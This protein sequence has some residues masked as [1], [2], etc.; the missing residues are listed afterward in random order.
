MSNTKTIAKNTG[1]YGVD[2]VTNV[3]VSA[4][5]SIAIARTLGPTKTGYIVFV[6]SVA[7]VVGSFGG[8]GIPAATRKSPAQFI[9]RGDK[10]TARYIFSRTFWMQFVLASLRPLRASSF[11]CFTM[12]TRSTVLPQRSSR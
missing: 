9:G 12:P 4:I 6:S 3:L 2:T 8:I 1:W 11:G 7:S 5:T 10:G